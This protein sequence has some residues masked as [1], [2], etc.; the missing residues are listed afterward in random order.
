MSMLRSS[1]LRSLL[2][3]LA[4]AMFGSLAPATADAQEPSEVEPASDARVVILPVQHVEGRRQRPV[5]MMLPPPGRVVR[6]G[7][8]PP[9]SFVQGVRRAA[10][11]RPF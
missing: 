7:D 3:G 5:V 2:L 4:L 6:D 8:R 1:T 9:P 10:T 11:R